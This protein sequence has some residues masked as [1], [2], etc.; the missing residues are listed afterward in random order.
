MIYKERKF[1]WL[2][3]L[4]DGKSR[5]TTWPLWGT[6]WRPMLYGDMA[7]IESESAEGSESS[8]PK[9]GTGDLNTEMVLI[10]SQKWE[11]GRGGIQK[12]RK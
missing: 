9:P 5:S 2:T 8:A 4:E 12:Q 6:W 3:V 11:M 7:E 10:C 1:I